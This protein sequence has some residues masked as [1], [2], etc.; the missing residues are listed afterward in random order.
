[1]LAALAVMVL[2]YIGVFFGR[3]L[4]AA[5]S[6]HRERL[7]D[8]SAV[9]FT[10]NPLGL[11]GALLKIAGVSSGSHLRSAEVEEVAHMLFASGMPRMF[12]THPSLEERLK[13]LNPSF[14]AS[15][16]PA[17]AGSRR[18][19]CAAPAPAGHGAGRGPSTQRRAQSA[20][21]AGGGAGQPGRRHRRP[22]GNHRHRTGALR[23]A[24]PHR[25]PGRRA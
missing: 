16:L 25:H 13:A 18:A 7:A 4:Q 21:R 24:R 1:M 19:R 20:C 12:A 9:Q 6:R 5:V 3:L 17:L 10:R 2:G 15:E 11:S 14:R 8:A 23:R 22:G